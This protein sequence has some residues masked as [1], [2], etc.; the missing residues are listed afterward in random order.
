[1]HLAQHDNLW[2]LVNMAT[3]LGMSQNIWNLTTREITSFSRILL[4]G[5]IGNVGNTLVTFTSC[6]KKPCRLSCCVILLL[7]SYY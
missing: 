4:V 2:S 5:N 7:S 6:T 3:K 1:M